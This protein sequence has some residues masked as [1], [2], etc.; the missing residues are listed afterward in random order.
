MR[1]KILAR[2]ERS[3]R[4]GRF[5][6]TVRILEPQVPRY[7]DSFRA[8]YLLGVSCLRLNDYGGAQSYLGRASSIEPLNAA[9]SSALALTALRRGETQRA[10]ETLLETLESSPRDARS[11]RI[12]AFVRKSADWPSEARGKGIARLMPGP[13]RLPGLAIVGPAAL[14]L[15]AAIVLALDPGLPGRLFPA[16][17]SPRTAGLALDLDASARDNPAGNPAGVALTIAE[18][19]IVLAYEEAVADFRGYKDNEATLLLNRILSSNAIDAIKKK[20]EFLKS[21]IL[22]KIPGFADFGG[23]PSYQE[24][25]SDPSAH[26]GCRVVFRGGIAN[27]RESPKEVTLVLLVGY[28]TGK[29]KL[30]DVP[31]VIPA[32]VAN[33]MKFEIRPRDGIEILGTIRSPSGGT[34]SL[35]AIS[36]HPLPLEGSR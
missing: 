34:L 33:A 4:K 12:L 1:D 17:P 29:I 11:R 23:G 7:R 26:D 3:Y 20:A 2:A 35:E 25:A 30:G 32:E 36:V 8:F 18:K 21:L 15:A 31:V 28:E 14:A 13:I 19:D 5:E 10:L 6:E 9:A 27:Y 24:V 22:R 16:P